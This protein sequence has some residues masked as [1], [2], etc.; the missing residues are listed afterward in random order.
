M[1]RKLSPRKLKYERLNQ[2]KGTTTNVWFIFYMKALVVGFF[3][4]KKMLRWLT[5]IMRYQ[6]CTTYDRSKMLL[7]FFLLHCSFVSYLLARHWQKYW[8]EREAVRKSF[9]ILSIKL[10]VPSLQSPLWEAYQ[11]MTSEKNFF[12]FFRKFVQDYRFFSKVS[13][14]SLTA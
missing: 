3:L 4:K 6:Q 14:F 12:T 7:F 1:P 13:N 10:F 11:P 9:Q 8:K 2:N 5:A